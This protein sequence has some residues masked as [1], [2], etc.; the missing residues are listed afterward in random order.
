MFPFVHSFFPSSPLFFSLFVIF[1]VWQPFFFL[2][3]LQ[4][5]PSPSSPACMLPFLTIQRCFEIVPQ[6]R[7]WDENKTTTPVFLPSNTFHFL[8]YLLPT[9]LPPPNPHSP[10]PLAGLLFCLFLSCLLCI[11]LAKANTIIHTEMSPYS[12]I[13]WNLFMLTRSLACVLQ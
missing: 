2:S 8:P 1:H 13:I 10:P 9:P 3:T 5:V 6:I 7:H 11:F 12:C 4:S